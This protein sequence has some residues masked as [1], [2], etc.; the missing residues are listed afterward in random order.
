[1]KTKKQLRN[2]YTP[3]RAGARWLEGA[4]P[5]VLD[6]FYDAKLDHWTVLYTG[7]LLHPQQGR[8]FSNTVIFGRELSSWPSHPQGVGISF[9]LKAHEAVRYRY[10]SGHQRVTWASLPDK[11]QEFINKEVCDGKS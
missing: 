4:P 5:H 10:R 6:L 11:V 2:S 9:E 8:D 7:G 1:M 3:R